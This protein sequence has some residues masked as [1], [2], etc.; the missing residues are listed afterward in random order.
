MS[1]DA[2][3]A[4]L[5]PMLAARLKKNIARLTSWRRRESVTCYRAYDR[6]MPELPFAVD[7]FTEAGTGQTFVMLTAWAPRHGG[8]STFLELAEACAAVA[9]DVV[10]AGDRVVVQ[11]REP[12]P[13]GELAHD[14]VEASRFEVVVEEGRGRF[15]LRLGARRDPGL[16]LD[17]RPTRKMVAD[18][19]TGRR[20]LNLFAYTGSFSVQAG[21][22]G[23]VA[24]LSV[25]LSASTC[26]WAEANLA[27]NGLKGPAHR[28]LQ[29]D[30]LTFL[31]DDDGFWD[32][33]VIDPP[34]FSKSRR[35]AG[36]FDVQRDHP[37]L[38]ARAA[39][40]LRS[41]GEIWFSCNRRDFEL[42]RAA[43][44][45]SFVVD[46]MT[47]A[48]TPPDFRGAP[49]VCFRLRQRSP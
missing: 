22:A 21:L 13:G 5:P 20:L 10:G 25:D 42:N 24:T 41:G 7:V 2:Q 36:T 46:D 8:G 27:E 48:T 30:V 31:D 19:V 32:V 14:E 43:L 17:H 37:T 33:I 26:R 15:H 39:A 35:V 12:G 11:V 29:A 1:L 45:T 23:A 16:F 38:I 3:K 4:A 9:A 18:V 49:H 47:A 44:P 34:S 28:V 40:R 6:D